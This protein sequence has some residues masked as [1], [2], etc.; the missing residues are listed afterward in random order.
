MIGNDGIDAD[1]LKSFHGF[2]PV[3]RIGA[4]EDVEPMSGFDNEVRDR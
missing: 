2:W 1:C 3:D 4:D